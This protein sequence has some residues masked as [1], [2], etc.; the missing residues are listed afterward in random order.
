MVFKFSIWFLFKSS[1]NGISFR[2]HTSNILLAVRHCWVGFTF[3]FK[4]KFQ[5]VF[6]VIQMA[7]KLK[8][9]CHFTRKHKT[10]KQNLGSKSKKY[11][12]HYFHKRRT[13]CSR[14]EKKRF[15]FP[16]SKKSKSNYQQPKRKTF[17]ALT[18]TQYI[19]HRTQ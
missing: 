16:R 10:E 9:S 5:L 13:S 8:I 3:T 7:H 4:T 6:I 15:F 19:T 1:L 18:S 12:F 17:I 14:Y 2:F 11:F